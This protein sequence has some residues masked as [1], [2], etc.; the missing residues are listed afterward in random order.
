MWVLL[1]LV[2]QALID[3]SRLLTQRERAD[4]GMAPWWW[5]T[6]PWAALP[7]PKQQGGRR[8]KVEKEGSALYRRWKAWPD[9]WVSEQVKSLSRVRLFAT[10]PSMG[11]SR[12]EYWS[13]LP[14]PSPGDLPDPRVEPRSPALQADTLT[15]EPPGKARRWRTWC[16]EAVNCEHHCNCSSTETDCGVGI[17]SQCREVYGS[18]GRNY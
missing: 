9:A 8:G 2:P 15:S 12:Q 17:L 6:I 7:W 10:P 5:R 1:S 13:G 3:W 4:G 16:M 18:S 11:F 14:F